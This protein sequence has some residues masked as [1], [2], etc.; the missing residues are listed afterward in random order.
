MSPSSAWYSKGKERPT[1][2]HKGRYSIKARTI[3]EA[4]LKERTTNAAERDIRKNDHLKK[5]RNPLNIRHKRMDLRIKP[6]SI[7]KATIISH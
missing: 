6:A 7:L 2:E 5:D 3:N 1:K 4:R